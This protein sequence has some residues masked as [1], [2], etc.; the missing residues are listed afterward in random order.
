MHAPPVPNICRAMRRGVALGV[1]SRQLHASRP[2]LA[3]IL[4]GDST[5]PVCASTFEARGHTVDSIPGLPKEELLK[6][7]GEY[8][9]LVVRSGVKVDKVRGGI[10]AQSHALP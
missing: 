10:G 1:H 2:A 4:L 8:D 7:I 9:G 6:I 3:R 5:D